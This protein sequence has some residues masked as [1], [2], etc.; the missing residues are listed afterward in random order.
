M[1][2][3][4]AATQSEDNWPGF[5]EELGRK[6]IDTTNWM[7]QLQDE[8]KVSEREL[9]LVCNAIYDVMSGLAD[10]NDTNLIYKIRNSLTEK[11]NLD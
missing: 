7:V 2:K 8:G 3:P 1:T 4:L 6:A 5:A 9:W 11:P 10:W